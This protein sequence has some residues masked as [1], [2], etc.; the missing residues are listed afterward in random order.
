MRLLI[1]VLW[2]VLIALAAW[3]LAAGTALLTPQELAF[4]LGLSVFMLLASRLIWGYGALAAFAQA[5]LAG[6]QPD[7]SRAENEARVPEPERLGLAALAS[8]WLAALEPYRYAF[9]AAYAVLFVI[10]LATKL[11]LPLPNA[12][13]W[14]TGSLL[15][16]GVFWGASAAVLTV[17]ALAQLATV[18]TIRLAAHAVEHES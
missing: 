16:E 9:Y 3:G 17:W 14:I 7:R 11:T 13:A 8:F 2:G 12:W 1:A 18:F 10:T 6:E 4:V 5:A 15:L